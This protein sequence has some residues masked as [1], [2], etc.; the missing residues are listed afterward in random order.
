MKR[1]VAAGVLWPDASQDRAFASLRVA[2]CKLHGAEGGVVN[3]TM[4]EVSLASDAT[5]DVEESRAVARQ[6]LDPSHGARDGEQPGPGAIGA[7]SA[8]LLPDWQEEW[9]QLEAE[10]W[11]Q[12]RM[13]ALEALAGRLT[14]EQRYGDAATAA[15]TAVAADPLRETS[16]A[17]LIRVHLA[18][19]NQSE[20]LR[21]YRRYEDVLGSELGLRPTAKLV[22]L[23]HGL[24]VQ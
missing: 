18:E 2:L 14:A 4:H 17:S 7:L 3:A 9:V 12:L 13:R 11:R 24:S 15:L 8:D 10:S 5:V 21:E 20:A 22:R 1:S 19:G 6:L 23:L 16:R